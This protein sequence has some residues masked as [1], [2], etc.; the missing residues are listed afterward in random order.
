LPAAVIL[1]IGLGWYVARKYER[2]VERAVVSSYQETQLEI[3]RAVARSAELYLADELAKHTQHQTIEQEILRRFV[4][5]VHLRHNGDAWIYAPDHIVF[6]LSTDLPGQYRGKSMAQIFAMQAEHGASHYR[7]MADDVMNSREGVGYYIWLPDKGPEIAAWTPV[8]LDGHVWTIGLSTPLTEILE[9]TG[10][11][12][13]SRYVSLAMVIA[14]ILGLG[15]SA[16]AVRSMLI[17]RRTERAITESERKYRTLFETATDGILILSGAGLMLDANPAA[18]SMYGRSRD[19]LA[20]QDVRCL[21]QRDHHPAVEEVLTSSLAGH[22]FRGRVQGVRKDGV[23]IEAELSGSVYDLRGQ[24][25]VLLNLRDLTERTKAEHEK[26][27]LEAKLARS[28]K[29]E[30]LGLLAGGVA[31][32]L[33]NILSGIVSYPDMLRAELN[34]GP[35]TSVHEML[36]TMQEAGT[37]AAAVVADLMTMARGS[38][39][40]HTIVSVNHLV[41]EFFLFGESRA[42]KARFPAVRFETRLGEDLPSIKAGAVGLTQSI[43]NLVQNSAEAI[44]GSGVVRITTRHQRVHEAIDGYCNIPPG[45]YVV[46]SICDSGTG[47]APHDL[48]RIFEPFY[49]RKQMGR[50]GTG[51]GLAIVWNAVQENSGYI[52]VHSDDSGSRFELYFPVSHEREPA[53]EAKASWSDL[54]GHGEKILIVDDEPRLRSI[55]CR[56]LAS[57]GYEPRAVSSGEEAVEYCKINPVDLLVLDMIMDP[58]INGRQTYERIVRQTPGQKAIIASGYADSEDVLSAQTLGV[59]ECLRKPYTMEQLGRSVLLELRK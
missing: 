37:R 9:A 17:N 59:G 1:V 15:L 52:D 25:C 45:N 44:Q 53:K 47:I 51:L 28:R 54:A 22:P 4:A 2:T 42:L 16:M 58:G 19:E 10:A 33:N 46:L 48:E 18:C 56:M 31:H 11:T 29:M 21:F 38:S 27:E 39:S 57:L 7:E 23:T 26:E 50:S 40:R 36:E 55:A 13:Q 24:Q 41:D 32:D 3:V 5:P 35:G 34:P 6:D 43:V 8:K 12:A 14:T 20:G 49:T 30:S